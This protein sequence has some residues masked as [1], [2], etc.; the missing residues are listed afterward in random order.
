METS[1]SSSQNG[2]GSEASLEKSKGSIWIVLNVT[3]SETRNEP[4]FKRA[5]TTQ[6]MPRSAICTECLEEVHADAGQQNWVILEFI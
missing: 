5:G 4:N 3:V 2:C 1:P 6:P